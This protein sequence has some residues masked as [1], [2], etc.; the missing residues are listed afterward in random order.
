MDEN[1]GCS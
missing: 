1:F